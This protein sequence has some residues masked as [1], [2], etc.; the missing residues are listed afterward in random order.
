MIPL[1]ADPLAWSVH[2]Q[3]S[4]P[5]SSLGTLLGLDA[6]D[7]RPTGNFEALETASDLNLA[8]A[9]VVKNSSLPR[10]RMDDRGDR[11]LQTLEK[12][13]PHRRTGGQRGWRLRFAEWRY[14]WE[15]GRVPNSFG[16]LVI[17]SSSSGRFQ[18]LADASYRIRTYWEGMRAQIAICRYQALHRRPPPDL[19][20]L[21]TARLLP[22]IP[23]DH[24]G[25]GPFRYNAAQGALWSLGINGKDDGGTSPALAGMQADIVWNI[26]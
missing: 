9:A 4:N 21:V 1:I 17:V 22:R 7:V 3:P 26:R 18:S 15:M 25:S 6:R 14:G 13:L 5:F 19:Q 16:R 11:Y 12:S 23:Y 20:T 8:L 24:L 2:K 10:N